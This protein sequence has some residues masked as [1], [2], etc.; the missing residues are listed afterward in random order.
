MLYTITHPA[1]A[2]DRIR[3][4]PSLEAA[5]AV[6]FDGRNIQIVAVDYDHGMRRVVPLEVDPTVLDPAWS[7]PA[8]FHPDGSVTAKGPLPAHLFVA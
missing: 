2:Y 4:F 3:L 7:A 1:E 5:R 8:Q 6:A